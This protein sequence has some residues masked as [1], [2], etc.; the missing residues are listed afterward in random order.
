MKDNPLSRRRFMECAALT[1][2]LP[3]HRIGA[4]RISMATASSASQAQAPARA[5]PARAASSPPTLTLFDPRFERAR[6]MAA[7][8]AAGGMTRPVNGDATEIMLWLSATRHSGQEILLQGVTLG[9]I[10]FCLGHRDPG[11]VR[12]TRRLDRDL[13]VWSFPTR[14]LEFANG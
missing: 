14:G 11:A 10:P 13:F 6:D 5:A 2:A 4:P 8:L 1:V 3:I 9:S 12:V 7:A